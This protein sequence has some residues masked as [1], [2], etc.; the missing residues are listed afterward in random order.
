[1]AVEG[2]NVAAGQIDEEFDDELIDLTD[3]QIDERMEQ[4]WDPELRT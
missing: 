4:A 2:D 3:E 1:M